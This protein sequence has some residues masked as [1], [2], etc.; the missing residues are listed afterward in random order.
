MKAQLTKRRTETCSSDARGAGFLNVVLQKVGKRDQAS[1]GIWFPEKRNV[2]R[3]DFHRVRSTGEHSHPFL[4]SD[5][6]RLG[7]RRSRSADKWRDQ[8]DRVTVF[9]IRMFSQFAKTI[10]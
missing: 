6:L 7:N 4:R 1:S 5:C 2:P 10:P 8:A 9:S 3:I